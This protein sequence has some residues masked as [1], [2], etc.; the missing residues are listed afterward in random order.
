MRLCKTKTRR[1]GAGESRPTGAL[2]ALHYRTRE[3]PGED[4]ASLPR[5]LDKR[6]AQPGVAVASP[7]AKT[8]T[9][10]RLRKTRKG[11]YGGMS[12]Q[13]ELSIFVLSLLGTRSTN[14]TP[15]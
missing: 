6:P 4:L 3:R 1:V 12:V 14:T 8:I 5:A 2:V 11:P 15:F 13:K 10:M 7:G 9:R